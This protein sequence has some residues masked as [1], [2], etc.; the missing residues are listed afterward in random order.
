[1]L[2]WVLIRSTPVRQRV[3]SRTPSGPAQHT[4]I[5]Q[6]QTR[7]LGNVTLSSREAQCLPVSPGPDALGLPA[8][9]MATRSFS[10]WPPSRVS[11]HVLPGIIR[12]GIAFVRTFCDIAL[13]ERRLTRRSC[14]VT[15][16]LGAIVRLPLSCCF[17]MPHGNDQHTWACG[18][19][20]RACMCAD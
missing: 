3:S 18:G 19:R 6:S 5:I 12:A 14:G 20:V 16:M 11:N 1:M 8:V 13:I 2:R 17:Q 15:E 10:R 4:G 9:R 7:L